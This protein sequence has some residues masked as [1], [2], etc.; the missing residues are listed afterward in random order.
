M[1]SLGL[2]APPCSAAVG[3]PLNTCV[4]LSDSSREKYAVA[5]G[6]S[7]WVKFTRPPLVSGVMP[8]KEMP[9]PS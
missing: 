8:E 2:P 3:P 1:F 5:P 9:G 6:A 7:G 4:A